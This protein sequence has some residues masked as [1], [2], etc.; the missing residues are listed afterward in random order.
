VNVHF[1]KLTSSGT[2]VILVDRSRREEGPI[3]A[4]RLARAILRRREGAG[5]DALAV[6]ERSP[7][8]RVLVRTYLSDGNVTAADGDAIVCAARY[9][10][11]AGLTH[12]DRFEIESPAGKRRIDVMTS[13]DFRVNLGPARG[14]ESG[15]SAGNIPF[16]TL[17]SGGRRVAVCSLEL[18]APYLVLVNQASGRESLSALEGAAG[19]G[20]RGPMAPRLQVARPVARDTVRLYHRPRQ[21][22][23]GCS[24]AGAALVAAAS[25][26]AADRE[27][28]IVSTSGVRY[29]EWLSEDGSVAVT[30]PAEYVYEGDYYLSDEE[31]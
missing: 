29:A 5:A 17:E 11:D 1:M 10:F 30:S 16:T 15:A 3:D 9:V 12:G 18:G 20:L 6:I 4:R 21:G 2:D 31:A 27:A 14:P 28:T 8:A 13:A 24:S 22:W 23:D 19:P 26:G 7:E 25:A